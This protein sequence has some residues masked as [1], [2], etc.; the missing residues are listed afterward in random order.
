MDA[1]DYLVNAYQRRH[2]SVKDYVMEQVLKTTKLNELVVSVMNI[3]FSSIILYGSLFSFSASNNRPINN[4]DSLLYE[5]R[6][7]LHNK[8]FRHVLSLFHGRRFDMPI[9]RKDISSDVIIDEI[10][11]F[12]ITPLVGDGCNAVSSKID[13][14]DTMIRYF[15]S[16]HG[17]WG[18]GYQGAYTPGLT[19]SDRLYL[20]LL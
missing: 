3:D 10:A 8:L 19:Q 6:E 15:I 9:I 7:S 14:S 11:D 18:Q 1:L 2:E 17:R 5:I 13:V 4:K 12:A 20:F 16:K